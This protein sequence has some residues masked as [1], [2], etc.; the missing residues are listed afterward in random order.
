[1]RLTTHARPYVPFNWIGLNDIKLTQSYDGPISRRETK[2][3]VRFKVDWTSGDPQ[4]KN[5]EH[6]Q[7][8]VRAGC[9]RVYSDAVH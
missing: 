9:S 1:M 5:H 4:V 7:T 2:C 3:Q 6:R 8:H